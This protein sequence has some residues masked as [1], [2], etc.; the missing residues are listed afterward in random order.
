MGWSGEQRGNKTAAACWLGHG[1]RL[2]VGARQLP[3]GWGTAA[4]R[5]C[6]RL[7]GQGIEGPAAA[8]GG[9]AHCPSMSPGAV[10]CQACQPTLP[11]TRLSAIMGEC[12]RMALRLLQPTGQGCVG[13]G[14]VSRQPTAVQLR[15]HHGG[16]G[17]CR[18]STC[19]K[20]QLATAAPPQRM[21]DLARRPLTAWCSC[22]RST[23]GSAAAVSQG[24]RPDCAAPAAAK[25][26]C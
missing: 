4:G 9:G 18:A 16:A 6:R 24:R 26:A 17:V 14:T 1:S 22:I 3:A 8:A 12:R 7:K 21:C 25:C 2:L 10:C 19:R 13:G 23:P 20:Q 11:V 5:V 15:S